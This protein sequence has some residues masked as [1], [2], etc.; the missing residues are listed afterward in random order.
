MFLFEFNVMKLVKA[1]LMAACHSVVL[2]IPSK[3]KTDG[4]FP[5]SALY[6]LQTFLT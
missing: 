3:K 5:K 6:A 1:K 4:V 2:N